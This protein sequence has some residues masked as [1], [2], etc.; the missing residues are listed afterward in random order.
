M[1]FVVLNIKELKIHVLVKH[2]TGTSYSFTN[3]Y[4]TKIV[5]CDLQNINI[6]TK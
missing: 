1:D 5:H 3:R 4:I 2:A 6:T